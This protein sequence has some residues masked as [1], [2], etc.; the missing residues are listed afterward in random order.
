MNAQNAVRPVHCAGSQAVGRMVRIKESS[1]A[2]SVAEQGTKTLTRKHISQENFA[3]CGHAHIE[4]YIV[5]GHN[6]MP[7]TSK[8][9]KS[10][11]LRGAISAG[12]TI[13]GAASF[14]WT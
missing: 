10:D 1:L 14:C 4:G 2:K 5:L 13:A 11:W 6:L 3:G 8:T 9:V 7:A 12:R